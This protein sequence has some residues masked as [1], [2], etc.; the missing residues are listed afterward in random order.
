[1]SLVTRCSNCGTS[2]R[3]LPGQLS[4]RNGRVRCGKCDAVFDG[5]AGLVEPSPQL[6]LSDPSRHNPPRVEH[7]AEDDDEEPLPAFM[8]E[9]RAP[10]R[11]VWTSLTA[12][13]LIA[14]FA[15]LAY[16][17]RAELAA[18]VPAARAPLQAACRYLNCEIRLPRLVKLLS[19]D[20][21]EVRADPRREG[22]IILNAVIRNRAPFPQEYPVLQLT[23]TDEANRQLVSRA[24]SP[25]EYLDAARGPQLIDRGIDP[26]AETSLTV[27]FDA[28]RTRA[29]GY[30]L[31]L[32][33]PS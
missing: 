12:L 13:A 11:A 22:V 10:R 27:Y 15:Q 30:E 28:S 33:Y 19:I 32:F 16:Y 7:V 2:F 1:V 8:A 14:L 26:G 25:R 17:F 23:L 9:P 31:V 5:I 29:T 4:A 3:V 18:S 21:Y 24:V 20:S 6:E